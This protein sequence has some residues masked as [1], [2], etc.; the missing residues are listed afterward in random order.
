MVDTILV[1]QEVEAGET[2]RA[3]AL[4]ESINQPDEFE[5]D[6]IGEVLRKE[7]VYTES[8]FLQHREGGDYVLYYI[9]AEDGT[10]VRD[11]F[12]DIRANPKSETDGL[13]SF[14]AEFEAVMAG[15]PTLV[16]VELL[17]HV[18]DPERPGIPAK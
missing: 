3:R 8:A 4:F 11:V 7:G 18:T 1:E 6:A 15:T 14:L 5:T 17:Y 2:E 9:E 16:D 13:E 10:Q 12:E